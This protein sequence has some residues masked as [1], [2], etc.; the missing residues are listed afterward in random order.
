[1]LVKYIFTESAPSQTNYFRGG[2]GGAGNIVRTSSL[3]STATSAASTTT[4][5]TTTTASPSSA[6]PRHLPN[7][8]FFS[9]IGGAGNVHQGAELQSALLDSLETSSAHNP[10]VGHVGRG[11]AGNVYS[12][13]GR[14][15]TSDAGS[16][17]SSVNSVASS[18][19]D[20]AK[21]WA[22][23]VSGAFARK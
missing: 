17:I 13:N 21:V 1:M 11:G 9:G 5:T 15:K 12:S 16:S 10:E 20:K 6:V 23:R 18:V 19:S 14:R 22:S 4:T 3:P 2:R 8:R 7:Q